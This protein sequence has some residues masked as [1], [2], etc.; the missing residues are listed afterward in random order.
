M[1]CTVLITGA[2]VLSSSALASEDELPAVAYPRLATSVRHASDF[3]PSGWKLVAIDTGELSG[4]RRPDV[5][6]LMRM[7]DPANVEP[8]KSS[9]SYKTDD[10]NPYLL[11]IGFGR[12][13]GFT[14]AASHYA[15]FPREIAPMHG[16][17][18]PGP[19]TVEIRRGVLTLTFGH[20]RGF[21]RLRFRWDG[22]AFSLVGYD[23]AGV[24]AG[25]FSS[26]SANYL[27]REARIEEGDVSSDHSKVST[28]GIRP[29]KRPTLE[30][31]NWEES[32]WTG[33]DVRG[34]S[35]GC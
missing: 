5:A 11:A 18:P 14:L 16:D 34:A 21:D 27:T 23:C 15:L 1:R 35:L 4:D 3:V 22:K 29:G 32:D 7:A 24:T 13:D 28:V 8:V 17:D 19:K 25:K 31:I 26:L 10:T 20:L 6:V 33:T 9:P 30:Q 12:R 2:L